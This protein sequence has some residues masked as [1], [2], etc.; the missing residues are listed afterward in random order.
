MHVRTEVAGDHRP[1]CTPHHQPTIVWDGHEEAA[2]CKT[3][4][5]RRRCSH[6]P[7]GSWLG[8]LPL[9]HNGLSSRRPERMGAGSRS[10]IG[11]VPQPPVWHSS[12]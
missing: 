11:K 12:H 6:L 9:A 7:P 2:Q 5:P 8:G 4:M 10:S 1:T 3:V